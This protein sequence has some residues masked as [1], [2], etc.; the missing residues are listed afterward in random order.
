MDLKTVVR[1]VLTETGLSDPHEVAAEVARR[2][3]GPDVRAALA[4]ALVVYV[5][6]QF[7]RDRRLPQLGVSASQVVSSKV[8]ACRDE[9]ARRLQTPVGVGG[10]WKHLAECTADDLR[11][12]AASL[13]RHAVQAA[14]KA[15]WYEALAASLPAGAV[16]GDLTADPVGVAA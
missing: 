8:T 1:Q 13:R 7:S 10:V 15:E 11:V 2:L 14:V 4:E 12:V 3:R 9:W 16:V 5:R 6:V